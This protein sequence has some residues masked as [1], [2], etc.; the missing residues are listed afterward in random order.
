MVVLVGFLPA[1][2]SAEELALS[3]RLGR[4]MDQQQLQNSQVLR[5]LEEQEKRFG[6]QQQSLAELRKLLEDQGALQKQFLEDQAGLQKQLL[7]KL[8]AQQAPIT[9]KAAPSNAT[10]GL[11]SDF[12]VRIRNVERL[13]VVSFAVTGLNAIFLLVTLHLLRRPQPV[14]NGA[15]PLPKKEVTGSLSGSKKKPEMK[16][17][18]FGR[19]QI[20]VQTRQGK[21]GLLNT[22]KI[23]ADHI[24]LFMGTS[25]SNLARHQ[26]MVTTIQAGG[27]I[28]LDL[29]SYPIH[30]FLYGNLEYKNP[31]N[32]KLFKDQFILKAHEQTGELMLANSVPRLEEIA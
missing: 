12:R 8:S 18:T 3:E 17:L 13:L 20:E 7:E 31:L 25:P 5:V 23:T 26:K 16:T 30:E 19:P 2:V 11:A 22:G 4:L 24:K 1:V 32:G 21:L 14:A 27:R 6:V 15:Q 10:M 28:E 29:A 9:I